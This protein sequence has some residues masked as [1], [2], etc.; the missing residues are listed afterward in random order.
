MCRTR[1]SHILFCLIL[2]AAIIAATLFWCSLGKAPETGTKKYE[3]A[4]F[5]Q[6]QDDVWNI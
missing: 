6:R 2:S 4:V 3:G 5:V 1:Q